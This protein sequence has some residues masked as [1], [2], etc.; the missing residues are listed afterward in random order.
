MT[1]RAAHIFHHFASFT[2]KERDRVP[3][4]DDDQL[5]EIE[6][7]AEEE[8]SGKGYGREKTWDGDVE[9]MLGRCSEQAKRYSRLRLS[10]RLD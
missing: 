7:C 4:T 3:R 6:E 1:D 8:E 5:G 2:D 10:C 9:R